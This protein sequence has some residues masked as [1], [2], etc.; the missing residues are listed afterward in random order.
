MGPFPTVQ[1]STT[2]ESSGGSSFLDMLG[3]LGSYLM[4]PDVLLP[5]VVG[6][7][8]TGRSLWPS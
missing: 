4:Q 5:G 6:G 3:G 2:E 7:L 8:L 1:A